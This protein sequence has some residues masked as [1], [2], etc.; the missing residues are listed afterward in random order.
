MRP[1]V[2]INV[3]RRCPFGYFRLIYEQRYIAEETFTNICRCDVES[4]PV[5][6]HKRFVH[7]TMTPS[8]V[9]AGREAGA[10]PA[11]PGPDGSGAVQ[12]R[13]HVDAHS[14]SSLF[15]RAAKVSV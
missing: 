4:F 7:E 1:D 10:P 12:Q 14:V 8:R 3:L 13:R 11:E 15:K 5:E 2:D 6:S 9:S